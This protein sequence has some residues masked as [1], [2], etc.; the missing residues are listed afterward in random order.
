MC[1][2]NGSLRAAVFALEGKS[3]AKQKTGTEFSVPVCVSEI[4]NYSMRS[5][6]YLMVY[7]TPFSPFSPCQVMECGSIAR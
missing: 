7:L 1:P 6:M 4:L 2:E 5:R 3:I